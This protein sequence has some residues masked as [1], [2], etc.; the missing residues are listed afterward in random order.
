MRPRVEPLAVV[1]RVDGPISESQ[2]TT[3]PLGD[4]EDVLPEGLI[5]RTVF[6]REVRLRGGSAHRPC[7][8][9]KGSAIQPVVVDEIVSRWRWR[10]QFWRRW[11]WGHRLWLEISK[12]TQGRTPLFQDGASHRPGKVDSVEKCRVP[13]GAITGEVVVACFDDPVLAFPTGGCRDRPSCHNTLCPSFG[14][15]VLGARYAQRVVGRVVGDDAA[16]TTGGVP[17]SAERE[18]HTRILHRKEL[19]EVVGESPEDCRVIELVEHPRG[20]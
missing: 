1:R 9:S 6:I 7:R 3:L 10:R 18:G 4:V 20:I 8:R 2:L 19:V 11:R 13:Q 15:G 14:R 16:M 5:C 12:L 17:R